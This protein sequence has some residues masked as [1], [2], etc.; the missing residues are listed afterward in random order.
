M[1]TAVCCGLKLLLLLQVPRLV[2]M[3]S[4]EMEDIQE[5]ASGEICAMFGVDCCSGDTFSD[6]THQLV[7][8]SM[9]VPSPV[10]S[11]AIEPKDR[12]ATAQFSKVSSS[13]VNAIL[14][15]SCCNWQTQLQGS[16][17]FLRQALNKFTKEDPTFRVGYDNET[18]QTIISGMG[19][20]HLEI[21]KLRMEREYNCEVKTGAPR[22]NYR[23]TIT[24][25]ATFDYTHK[26]QSGGQGQYGKVGAKDTIFAVAHHAFLGHWW[27]RASLG[28]L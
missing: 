11:L 2:R 26:K 9:H 10:M 20:L 1:G 27:S 3:H 7:M 13:I 18:K 8:T 17:F 14:P 6:G 25:A 19:E 24:S 21:Y 16:N 28:E 15:V 5:A 22:V 4:D 12:A 23:E